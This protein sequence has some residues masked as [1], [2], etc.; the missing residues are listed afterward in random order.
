M[1]ALAAGLPLAAILALMLGLHWSA[2][3][4]GA[5]GLVLALLV[6]L[7]VFGFGDSVLP[8]LGP[9]RAVGFSVL[10][11]AFTAATILWIVFPALCLYEAQERAGAFVAIR[12][13]LA[14]VSDDPRTLALLVAFFFA[15]FMEGAAGFGT[16]VA[17]AAPLLVSL[18]FPPLKAVALALIGHAAGVSF[19]AV[20][21]PVIAQAEI[22]GV[23]AGAIAARTALMHAIAGI[24]L[25]VFVLRLAAEGPLRRID[26]ALALLAAA[27]FFVPSL[28]LALLVGPEVPTLGGALVGLV[29][30]VPLARRIAPRTRVAADPLDLRAIARAALPYAVLL[31]LILATR[32]VPPLQEAL[33]GVALAWTLEGGFSGRF[34]PLY[35]PGTLLMIGFLAG[36]LVQGGGG[37]DLAVATG[38]AA[39]RLAPVVLALL[40]M[41]AI[42]RIMVH[43]GMIGAL[44]EAAAAI[45]PL[46]PL[47]APA[48]GVL[49]TFV[50]GSATASNILLSE[51]QAATARA[52]ALDAVPL[53]AA[54]SF[55][56]A[57]GNI[58]C[59]H[60]IIAGG[61]T[62]GLAGREGPAMRLT[63]GACLAYALVGGL[64]ALAFAR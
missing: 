33:R 14:R 6:A 19:G 50:T 29:L 30:F 40:A 58:V 54:Q 63:V 23:D 1:Q 59:P 38:A 47:A 43:A 60:N 36:V 52:L 49:G 4:A 45:G 64:L 41:L 12:S 62:V 35:H 7:V 42:A 8:A 18:G 10:E 28:A 32:L 56:A 9:T 57:V 13:A 24:V 16:P 22:T 25:V 44:A 20:G 51:F 61:A 17:L 5:V 39:R 46:W 3:R 21:T 26:W 37:R 27:C 48:V 31:A 34:E 53:L 2:V 11:A 15:L 55:G